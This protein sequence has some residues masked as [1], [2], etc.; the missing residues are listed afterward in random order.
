M[1][2]I[3]LGTLLMCTAFAV[4]C[5]R[6]LSLSAQGD[7]IVRIWFSQYTE[8]NAA[9]KH[10]NPITQATGIVV[11]VV[12]RLTVFNAAQI[13]PTTSNMTKG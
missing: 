13:S 11:E 1:K 3:V 10:R 4:F 9:M 2:K 12:P 8:E 6:P 7:G 5:V